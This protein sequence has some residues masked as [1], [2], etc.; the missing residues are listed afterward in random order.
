MSTKRILIVDDSRVAQ[1]ALRRQLEDHAFTIE[2]ADSG[3]DALK[4]LSQQR[5]PAAIFLDHMMPGMDGFQALAAIKQNPAMAAI[6]VVMYT[7]QEGEQYAQHARAL[8]ASAVLAKPIKALELAKV[9]QQLHLLGESAPS[10]RVPA[11]AANEAERLDTPALASPTAPAT[12]TPALKRLLEEQR[13]ALRDDLYD[14]LREAGALSS[15]R[16]RRWRAFM[17]FAAM[18]AA[19]AFAF[20]WQQARERAQALAQENA[21][22]AAAAERA[23]VVQRE[24]A[25]DAAPEQRLAPSRGQRRGDGPLLAA[26]AWAFNLAGEYDYDE[27]PLSDTRVGLVRDL[28]VR[29]DQA[30]FKG[31]VRLDTHVAEFCLERSDGV[32]RVPRDDAPASRCEVVSYAPEYA[33]NLSKRQSVGFA[34]FLASPLLQGGIRIEIVPH[35]KDRPLFAYPNVYALQS[36]GEWNRIARRNQRVEVT[37]VPAS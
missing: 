26:L 12:P 35:G 19:I 3:E 11:M 5:P 6:P 18:L 33:F 4:F 2:T 15:P 1:V 28:V 22:L 34:R 37:L 21:R 27:L 9:L 20:L 7:S 13:Y 31:T 25:D 24:D 17:L 23:A 8:G 30:G 32:L 16:L 10:E 14:L 29:L 36:A